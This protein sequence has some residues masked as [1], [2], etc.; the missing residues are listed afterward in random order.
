MIRYLI[1][2]AA[3]TL[4]H[5]PTIWTIW[6]DVLQKHD[7][8]VTIKDLKKVH[9]L[10]SE[11]VRFPDRTSREF[12]IEFNSKVLF[13]L[14]VLPTEGLKEDLFQAL[15][16]QP[17]RAFEDVK[18]LKNINL[19]KVVA[20]NFKSDLRE[21][22]PNM[23]QTNFEMMFVSEELQCRKPD[24]SFYQRVIDGIG[25]PPNE[26]LYIGDSLE[27]DVLPART[28]GIQAYLIDREND[29]SNCKYK[30]TSFFELEQLIESLG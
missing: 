27:L 28:L 5:K 14:G 13:N 4:I 11:T 24:L 6:I 25:I 22:L 16:Y 18:S 12:Y 1:F 20:S 9:K 21:W 17:W 8:N 23:V 2:D 10:T 26:M 29:Y 30:I 19:P 15:T 3:N 7:Y